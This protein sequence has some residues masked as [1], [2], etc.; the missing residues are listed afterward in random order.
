MVFAW[1]W[2]RIIP[3]WFAEISERTHTPV[4]VYIILLIGG[5]IFFLMSLPPIGL[6]LNALAYYSILLSALTWILPGFN[7]LL[8]PFRRKDIFESSGFKK[9]IAGLPTLSWL[10]LIWIIIIVPIYVI[11]FLQP[12]IA[13]ALS[14]PTWAYANNSGIVALVVIV[15]IGT[16]LYFA[17]KSIQR[18][19]GVDIDLIFKSVPPE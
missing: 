13:G 9:K 1:A 17:G 7:A 10:G 14:S 4:T 8:L 16:I 6:N 3:K 12:L 19:R 11:A 18:S 15:A 2:D 5:L